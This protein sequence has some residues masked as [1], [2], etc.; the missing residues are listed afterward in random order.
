MRF[1][2]NAGA[3]L[4]RPRKN[5]KPLIAIAFVGLAEA[6]LLSGC[7]TP[8]APQPPS[9]KLP[10]RVTDLTAVRAG[11]SVVLNFRWAI[12]FRSGA[13]RGSSGGDCRAVG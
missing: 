11:N 10:E 5:R 8:G 13:R 6:I 4:N 9:L 7:G 2:P 3:A 12:K 1:V